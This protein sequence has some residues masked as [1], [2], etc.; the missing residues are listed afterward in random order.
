MGYRGNQNIRQIGD[1]LGVSHVLEGSVRKNGSRIHI[2]AQLIDSRT[3]DSYIWAEEY[4]RG[5]VR[6]F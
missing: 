6:C 3:T 2:N 1:A 5:C 4:D